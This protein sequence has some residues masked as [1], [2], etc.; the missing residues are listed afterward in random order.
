M[1]K[2]ARGTRVAP[3]CEVYSG[4]TPALLMIPAHLLI[5]VRM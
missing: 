3:D 5:S 2:V 4:F 1:P